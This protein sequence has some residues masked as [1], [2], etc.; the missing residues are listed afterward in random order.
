MRSV[1][2]EN[3]S[4][5]AKGAPGVGDGENVLGLFLKDRRARLDAGALGFPTQ[6]RR[7]PGLRREEVAQRANV[8]ATWY[9]WLEQGRGGAPSADVIDRLS[10]ALMLTPAE[11]E[12]FHKI[13]RTPVTGRLTTAYEITDRHRRMLDALS[14]CPAYIKTAAWDLVA[15]NAAANTVLTDYTSLAPLERNILRILFLDPETRRGLV[16]WERDARHAVETFRLETSRTPMTEPV[17]SLIRELSD[18]SEDFARMW[19]EHDVSY[20]A[21]GRKIVDHPDAGTIHLDYSSFSIDEQPGLG[22]VIYAPATAADQTRI[23]ELLA[24]DLR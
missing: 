12:Y 3:S 10:N 1:A 15:W 8:S 21:Q 6:R 14:P 11:R 7:T 22:L 18:G 9:T 23:L 2:S 13:A 20:Y 16:H 17:Q 4:Q 5:I 24:R 19:Q